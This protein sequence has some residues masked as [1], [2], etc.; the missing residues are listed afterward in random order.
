MKARSS[1]GYPKQEVREMARLSVQPINIGEYQEAT[2]PE[3]RP[4]TAEILCPVEHLHRRFDAAYDCAE[5]L[6]LLIQSR[7]SRGFDCRQLLG[8][9]R[10]AE[11]EKRAA[12]AALRK[13]RWLKAVPAA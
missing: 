11:A 5:E 12:L 3:M 2:A 10:E 9:L 7:Q 4:V 13:A 8:K 6:G 1:G